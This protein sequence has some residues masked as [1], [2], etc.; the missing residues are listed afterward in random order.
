MADNTLFLISCIIIFMPILY[1]TFKLYWHLWEM[2][3]K[4]VKEIIK[5]ISRK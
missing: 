1:G 3:A 4:D 2:L 5:Y